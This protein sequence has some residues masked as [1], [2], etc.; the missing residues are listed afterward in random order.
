MGQLPA[1][2][3]IFLY[4]GL[5]SNQVGSSYEYS[6]TLVALSTQHPEVWTT[7]F[8]SKKPASRRLLE[9]LKRGSQSGSV[10]VWNNLSTLFD[11]LPKGLYPS[12]MEEAR[13]ILEAIRVGIVSK[14]EPRINSPAAWS[15]YLHVSDLMRNALTPDQLQELYRQNVWPLI[16]Q[17]VQPRPEDNQWTIS[18]PQPMRVLSKAVQTETIQPIL[19]TES[20]H[21]S[22]DIVRGMQEWQPEANGNSTDLQN[23]VTEQVTRWASVQAEALK[24]PLS[25]TARLRF[26]EASYEILKEAVHLLRL[27]DGKAYD[28]AAVIEVVVRLCK[29]FLMETP[30]IFELLTS[31]I[32]RD[33]P[34]LFLSP[35]RSALAA[36]LYNFQ[37]NSIFEASWISTLSFI[38][39]SPDLDLQLLGLDALLNSPE[40]PTDL[41]VARKASTLQELLISKLK[42]AISGQTDWIWA[43]HI[44]SYAKRAMSSE[45]IARAL[46][47]LMECLS[48]PHDVQKAL[49]AFA[50]LVRHSSAIIESYLKTSDGSNFLLALLSLS[51]SLDDQLATAAVDII[52]AVE[53]IL[54]ENVDTSSRDPLFKALRTGINGEFSKP[55]SV[56]ALVELAQ[57]LFR[58]RRLDQHE[59]APRLLPSWERW[60]TALQGFLTKAPELSSEV[61]SPLRGAIYLV[62][63]KSP[64]TGLE[65]QLSSLIDS[66]GYSVGL[67]MAQYITALLKSTKVFD[68]LDASLRSR[69]Y[70]SLFLSVMLADDNL[71]LAGSNNF[72]HMTGTEPDG[73]IPDFISNAHSLMNGWLKEFDDRH[74]GEGSTSSALFIKSALDCFWERARGCSAE[75]YYNARAAALIS[76]EL[77]DYRGW[78]HHSIAG[79]EDTLMR[80]RKSKGARIDLCFKG[81]C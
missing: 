29:G 48:T 57:R 65:N 44:L 20:V 37:E 45:S 56:E 51:E 32:E 46:D 27:Y 34:Q 68:Q 38:I 43:S 64:K 3:N 55:V 1:I 5:H 74:S 23:A 30:T 77:F 35:S 18:M 33:M 61:M 6:A 66:E 41:D 69:I 49:N 58:D 72:W 62:E 47:Y 60:S 63:P 73:D 2:S 42:M 9:F 52:D 8:P 24:G 71:S 7:H 12:E 31:F 67:R 26:S 28:A 53:K 14:E 19:A 54:S 81:A 21:L 80:A 4:K 25:D 10:E 39:H 50:E 75:A 16:R 40:T 22:E 76:A 78:T 17:Y 79:V 13:K 70:E 59:T 15:T 36:V 11:V